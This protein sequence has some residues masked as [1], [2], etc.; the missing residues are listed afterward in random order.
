ML[1]QPFE[2]WV[3]NA[4]VLRVVDG[5]TLDLIVD[6]G[7]G[8]FASQR[9]VLARINAPER[10]TMEGMQVETFLRDVFLLVKR[11]TV[12]LERNP[13]TRDRDQGRPFT[14]EIWLDNGENLS[15]IMVSRGL[16][17]LREDNERVR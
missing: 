7:L 15:D 8:I 6:L 16:V 14:A 1:T 3:R 12:K 10:T 9:V 2:D 11:V 13:I 5:D 17:S 4:D